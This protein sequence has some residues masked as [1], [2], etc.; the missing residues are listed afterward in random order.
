MIIPFAVFALA[1][2]LIR[3]LYHLCNLPYDGMI[4]GISFSL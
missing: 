4:K 3:L 2:L 1:N